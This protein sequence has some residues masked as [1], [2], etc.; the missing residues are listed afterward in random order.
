MA[1]TMPPVPSGD[2]S[3]TTRTSSDGSC[4][5]TAGMRRAM[6]NRSLYVGTMTSAR[7]AKAAPITPDTSAEHENADEDGDPR[8]RSPPLI[9]RT[10]EAQV[11]FSRALWQLDTNQRVVNASNVGGLSIGGC[12]P[13]PPRGTQER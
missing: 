13:H 8:D 11:N 7:S 4:A 2:P 12:I 1:S 6:L 3:S 5:R 9:G 10:G